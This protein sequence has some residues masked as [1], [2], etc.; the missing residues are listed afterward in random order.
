M[1][2][3]LGLSESYALVTFDFLDIQTTE[4]ALMLSIP[5]ECSTSKIKC[6]MADEKLVQM[7]RNNYNSFGEEF[8]RVV[9]QL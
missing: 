3:H 4:R 1:I 8:I 7:V 2:I 6:K 9:S 5:S